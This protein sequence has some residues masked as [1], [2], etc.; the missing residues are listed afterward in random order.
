MNREY[1]RK[2]NELSSTTASNLQIHN[3]RNKIIEL[4]R[5]IAV[6]EAKK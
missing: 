4:E 5:R 6:L 1:H 2:Y 3:L